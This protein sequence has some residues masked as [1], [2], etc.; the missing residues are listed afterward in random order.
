MSDEHKCDICKKS[1]KIAA[2][3]KS[4][5]TR[6][7]GE[8]KSKV[9][10]VP[11]EPVKGKMPDNVVT[12]TAK[13]PKKVKLMIHHVEGELDYVFVNITGKDV[14]VKGSPFRITRGV[15]V[16]VPEEV[17]NVLQDAIVETFRYDQETNKNIPVSYT[18][19]PMT[20]KPIDKA[21]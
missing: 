17:V 20:I 13:Q 21:A 2:A 4:H 3:L 5:N 12:L 6:F 11:I 8:G 9:S 10:P 14:K 1:F 7:H 18:K 19:Y 16:D 15:F